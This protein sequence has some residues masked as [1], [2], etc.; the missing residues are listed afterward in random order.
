MEYSIEKPWQVMNKGP[1]HIVENI[2]EIFYYTHKFEPVVELDTK[3]FNGL[4]IYMPGFFE[5]R[6]LIGIGD[7]I[8]ALRKV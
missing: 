2:I 7:K 4:Q 6:T 8:Y 1:D 5:G 3:Y